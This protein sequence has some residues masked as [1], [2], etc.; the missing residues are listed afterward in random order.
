MN[1]SSTDVT[2]NPRY[3]PRSI[4]LLSRGIQLLQIPAN[5]D[6]TS[7]NY[8]LHLLQMLKPHS[9]LIYNPVVE[10]IIILNGVVY[11]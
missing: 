7:A 8:L 11:D 9:Q 3:N 2:A 1:P 5:P 10:N 4:K 6:C